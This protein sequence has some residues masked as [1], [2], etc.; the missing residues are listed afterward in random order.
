MLYVA[1]LSKCLRI[2]VDDTRACGDSD[3]SYCS[4]RFFTIIRWR[5]GSIILEPSI[6][7]FRRGVTSNITTHLGRKY[8]IQGSRTNQYFHVPLPLGH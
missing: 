6:D 1:K 3:L 8:V 5:A 7:I 2:G 4:H